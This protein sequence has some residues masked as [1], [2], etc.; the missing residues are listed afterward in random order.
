MANCFCTGPD[1]TG[2]CRCQRN[3]EHNM[4]GRI[5][6][7]ESELENGMSDPR[8][9]VVVTTVSTFRHRYVMHKDDLRKLNADVIPSEADLIDWAQD[10]VTMGECEEF[11]QH[12][13]G[14]QISDIYACNEDEMLTL[15]DRDNEYLSGWSKEKKIEW[16]R[17]NLQKS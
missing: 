1:S 2:K 8:E 7:L 3:E 11:S 14:E 12:H 4:F 5:K 17:N 9:Y 10:T 13:L 16:V 6:E 15:F